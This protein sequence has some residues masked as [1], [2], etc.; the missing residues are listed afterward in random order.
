MFYPAAFQYHLCMMMSTVQMLVWYM[1]INYSLTHSVV[2]SPSW[3]AKCDSKLAYINPALV[4]WGLL[5]SSPLWLTSF[6]ETVTNT[7]IAFDVFLRKAFLTMSHTF[8]SFCVFPFISY[9]CLFPLGHKRTPLYLPCST[10]NCLQNAQNAVRVSA[11]VYSKVP[12]TKSCLFFDNWVQTCAV[13]Y[14]LGEKNIVIN[15]VY[16][17]VFFT[18]GSYWPHGTVNVNFFMVPEQC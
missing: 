13:K 17:M 5:D 18:V 3:A 12:K 14:Y 6:I 16:I 1:V 4:P 10:D 8:A 2:Q 15:C 11:S 7:D 9:L